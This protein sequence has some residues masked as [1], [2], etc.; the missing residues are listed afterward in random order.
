MA[1]A[2]VI[3]SQARWLLEHDG[4][5]SPHE[6]DDTD[7]PSAPQPKPKKSPNAPG[8]GA[9]KKKKQKTPMMVQ[10]SFV[11]PSFFGSISSSSNTQGMPN[12]AFAHPAMGY[13]Y[14]MVP[15]Q[16]GMQPQPM[17]MQMGMQPQPM[18][19]GMQPHPMQMGMQPQVVLHVCTGV[20]EHHH[21]RSTIGGEHVYS[22]FDIELHELDVDS[23][24]LVPGESTPS[25]RN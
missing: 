17:Q 20:L 18:H 4:D 13:N 19:M 24:D 8:T 9:R 15:M 14:K 2:F 23:P 5:S 6:D 10:P 1:M 16:M 7:D 22:R 21:N 25:P 11:Q 12:L 3:A